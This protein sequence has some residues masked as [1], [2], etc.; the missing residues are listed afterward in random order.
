MATTTT[1]LTRWQRANLACRITEA[2]RKHW[3]AHGETGDWDDGERYLRDEAS[4][5]ELLEE[6]EKWSKI[7]MNDDEE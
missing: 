3:E 2:K 1:R 5:E 4:D 6:C 7:E